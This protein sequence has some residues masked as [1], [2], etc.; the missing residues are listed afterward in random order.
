MNRSFSP[1]LE[2]VEKRDVPSGAIVAY[3]DGPVA[4][5]GSNITFH[6]QDNFVFVNGQYQFG[7]HLTVNGNLNVQSNGLA[8]GTVSINSDS[9][10]IDMA[11]YQLYPQNSQN[12]GQ[13]LYVIQDDNYGIAAGT[14]GTFQYA[15]YG[16]SDVVVF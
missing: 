11:V 2:S 5:S 14:Q 7:G 16:S 6:N 10:Y 9:H 13:F 1:Q 8:V 3:S 15:E 4:H 12:P